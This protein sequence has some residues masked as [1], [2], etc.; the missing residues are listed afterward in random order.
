MQQVSR[1]VERIHA[2]VPH[3]APLI[4]AGDFNDWREKASEVLH[5]ELGIDEVFVSRYGR[6]PKTFPVWFPFLRLDRIYAR[7]LSIHEA[8]CLTGQPWS[9]LSDHAALFADLIIKG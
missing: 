6:H 3:D 7:G 4:V 2:V 8:Q 1:L 9:K 5:E